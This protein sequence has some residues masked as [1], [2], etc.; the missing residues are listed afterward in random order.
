MQDVLQ[1]V[2][3]VVVLCNLVKIFFEA[4]QDLPYHH[5][6]GPVVEPRRSVGLLLLLVEARIDF[7]AE[8]DHH[9]IVVIGFAD[10]PEPP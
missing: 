10:L 3:D 2:G 5:V 8:V 6:G 9:I 1:L 7:V 4:P